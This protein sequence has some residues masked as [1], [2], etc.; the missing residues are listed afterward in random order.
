MLDDL[1]ERIFAVMQR[2]YEKKGIL[3]PEQIP[4]FI[5]RLDPAIQLDWRATLTFQ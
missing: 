3:L 5:E 4:T 1:T 2:P